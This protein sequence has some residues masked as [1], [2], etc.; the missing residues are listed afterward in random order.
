MI[1]FEYIVNMFQKACLVGEDLFFI[2]LTQ[3]IDL[4]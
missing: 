1:V 3:T 2:F 4:V